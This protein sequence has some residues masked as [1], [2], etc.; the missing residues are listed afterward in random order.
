MEEAKAGCDGGGADQS[1]CPTCDTRATSVSTVTL[2]HLLE[3]LNA[4]DVQSDKIYS[5]CQTR[6]CPILYFSNDHSQ[7]F[8]SPDVRTTVGFKQPEDDPPHPVCYC[9]GYTKEN[10]A[11]EIEKTG[12]S[13][14]VDWITERVQADECACE[15][16]NPTGQCCL[17]DVRSVLSE[18]N[19]L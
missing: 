16:K 4:R 13:T 2:Y 15:Y 5:V 6:S 12:E 9:F 19:K 17:G 7:T 18:I 10:I 11:E 3:P 14:V 8:E 1:L